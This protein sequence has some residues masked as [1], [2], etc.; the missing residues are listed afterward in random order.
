ML[1]NGSQ[2]LPVSAILLLDQINLV[3]SLSLWALLPPAVV[4]TGSILRYPAVLTLAVS[5]VI[6]LLIGIGLQ[7]FSFQSGLVSTVSGFNVE[8]LTGIGI[9]P[10]NLGDNLITLLNRGGL[11]SMV[12]TLLV[13]IS[14]FLLA[15]GMEVS[16]GLNKIIDSILNRVTTIFS[17]IAVTMS[18]GGIMI[19]LT[20]HGGVTALIVGNLFQKAF[21]EH[22]L[23]PENLSRSMEDSVAIVEPLMPWTVSAI[24]MAS[25]LSVPTISY[26]PWATFCYSGPVF[27]LLLAAAFSRTRFGLKRL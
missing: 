13:I 18:S 25:T 24:F 3:Y 2:G 9:D 21:K 22:G 19:S 20:S 4:L 17:L 14:A 27:S 12:D 26:L 6:A 10:Q 15:G 16:G 11:Y 5:S 23:A 7:G 8:M 1:Q